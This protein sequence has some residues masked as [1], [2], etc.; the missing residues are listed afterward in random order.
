ME[1]D[2]LYD[3]EWNDDPEPE[4]PLHLEL[5]YR[6]SHL[7][8]LVQPSTAEVVMTYGK[9]FYDGMPAMTRNVYGKGKAYADPKYEPEDH[10]ALLNGY[11]GR[12]LGISEL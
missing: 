2:G 7:C 6:C 11:R 10:P 5:A 12:V 9:D 3:G 1:I 8:E 4:N